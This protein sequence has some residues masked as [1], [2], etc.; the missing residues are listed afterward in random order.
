MPFDG[1]QPGDGWVILL[2][3]GADLGTE[4]GILLNVK[5]GDAVAFNG[6]A[7]YRGTSLIRNR[8]PPRTTIGP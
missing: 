6:K 2:S 1:G 3:L 7:V 5:S 8:H 4:H